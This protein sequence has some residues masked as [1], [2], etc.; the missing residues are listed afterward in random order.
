VVLWQHRGGVPVAGIHWNLSEG[1]RSS[2][3]FRTASLLRLRGVDCMPAAAVCVC[4]G[5][6]LGVGRSCAHFTHIVSYVG[7]WYRTAYGLGSEDLSSAEG[8]G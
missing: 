4:R 6:S 5:V 7:R 1:W 3:T 2:V 8:V